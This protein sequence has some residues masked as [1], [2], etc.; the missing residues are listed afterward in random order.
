LKGTHLNLGLQDPQCQTG[1]Q[2]AQPGNNAIRPQAGGDFVLLYRAVLQKF[3]LYGRELHCPKQ[4][5]NDPIAAKIYHL[6]VLIEFN[7][8]GLESNTATFATVAKTRL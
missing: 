2:S 6:F 1:P 5:Q 4:L 8:A 7:Q 3:R